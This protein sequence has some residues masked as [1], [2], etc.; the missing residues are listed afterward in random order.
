MAQ[1][2]PELE[3]SQVSCTP[4]QTISILHAVIFTMLST[5]TKGLRACLCHTYHHFVDV[6]QSLPVQ[7]RM[8]GAVPAIQDASIWDTA[9]GGAV[10]SWLPRQEEA[11]RCPRLFQ[12]H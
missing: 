9:L 7:A 11:D 1:V 4:C 8:T 12:V 3:A 2:P 6:K 5:S 10:S